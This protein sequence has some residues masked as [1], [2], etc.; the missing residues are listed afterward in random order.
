MKYQN[1]PIIIAV[2][3]SWDHK[4]G[5][6][7]KVKKINKQITV[8]TYQK[9]MQLRAVATP[10]QTKHLKGSIYYNGKLFRYFWYKFF[11]VKFFILENVI[12]KMLLPLI[13]Q[14]RASFFWSAKY[15]PRKINTC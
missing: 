6:K 11:Y 2:K 7:E 5:V 10:L 3:S 9:S 8:A 15:K 4:A 1:L 13:Y 14:A 12:L